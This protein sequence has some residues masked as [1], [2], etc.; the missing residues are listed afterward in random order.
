MCFLADL[1][2]L[3]SASDS[4]SQLPFTQGCLLSLFHSLGFHPHASERR[5]PSLTASTVRLSLWFEASACLDHMTPLLP[6]L[7]IR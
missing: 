7:A 5:V 3:T 1:L 4:G 6:P 2:V